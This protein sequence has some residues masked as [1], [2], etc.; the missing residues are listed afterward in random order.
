[1]YRYGRGDFRDQ[2]LGSFNR[3]SVSTSSRFQYAHQLEGALH[4]NGH[5]QTLHIERF[6]FP[7][8]V[9]RVLF[10]LLFYTNDRKVDAFYTVFSIVEDL[11]TR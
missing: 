9:E 1:M 8:Y 10:V 3:Y 11:V 4:N 7:T 2:I 5:E 6:M